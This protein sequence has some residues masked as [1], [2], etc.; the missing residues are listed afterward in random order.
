MNPVTS[1]LMSPT[2]WRGEAFGC[3][4]AS[5]LIRRAMA[6]ERLTVSCPELQAA[7]NEA[8]ILFNGHARLLRLG[9]AAKS[10]HAGPW[11]HE[12]MTAFYDALNA[13]QPILEAR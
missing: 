5:R 2:W 9:L 13:A 8:A 4:R 6:G 3:E 10:L 12:T 11:T 7:I 1:D